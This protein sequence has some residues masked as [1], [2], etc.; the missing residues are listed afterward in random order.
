MI[1]SPIDN[2]HPPDYAVGR[3]E[4]DGKRNHIVDSVFIF[5]EFTFWGNAYKLFGQV[6]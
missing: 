2:L 3:L 4:S 6:Q 5:D 1:K